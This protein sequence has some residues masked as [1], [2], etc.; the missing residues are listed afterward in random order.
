MQQAEI[1]LGV[2]LQAAPVCAPVGAHRFQQAEG[3]DDV[4]L[5]EVFRAVDRTIDMA[6]GGEIEHRARLVFGQ[7]IRHQRAVAYVAVHEHVPLITGQR[8]Q[9]FAVARIGQRIEVDDRFA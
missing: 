6:F 3:A 9:V 2:A 1:C 5:D 8:R 4:G 7:Q